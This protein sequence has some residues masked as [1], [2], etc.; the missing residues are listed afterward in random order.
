MKYLFPLKIIIPTPYYSKKGSQPKLS[1]VVTFCHSLYHSL[2]FVVTCCATHCYSFSLYV[3]HV[4]LFIN[5]Q[6]KLCSRCEIK[7]KNVCQN[8]LLV[9]KFIRAQLFCVYPVVVWNLQQASVRRTCIYV[10]GTHRV[11]HELHLEL[12]V[13]IWFLFKPC[14]NRNFHKLKPQFIFKPEGLQ[15]Y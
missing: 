3:P 1:L 9:F 13:N 15:L 2:S 6:I 4:C 7:M 5:N 14:L 11:K 8:V 12:H 10:Y